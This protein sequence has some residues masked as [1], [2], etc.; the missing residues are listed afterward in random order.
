[1]NIKNDDENIINAF[2]MV[3]D[4]WQETTNLKN[5]LTKQLQAKLNT[6][7]NEYYQLFG[8]NQERII[9]SIKSPTANRIVVWF[10]M[11]LKQKGRPKAV[12]YVFFSICFAK[13]G[14]S[15]EHLAPTLHVGFWDVC[16]GYELGDAGFDFDEIDDHARLLENR[17]FS[18]GDTSTLNEWEFSYA[19][20][21]TAMTDQ[22]TLE[23]SVIRPL[24]DLMSGV[25][26]LKALPDDL[27]GLM[28]FS[29]VNVLC[30]Y[31]DEGSGIVRSRAQ[32]AEIED[33][34][35]VEAESPAP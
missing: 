11:S 15:P 17:L 8:K 32:H 24:I 27:P 10:P 9:K 7:D 12:A 5:V 14:I 3:D 13:P 4:C 20:H 33:T 26:V 18:W 6:L 31:S 1:M 22:A 28:K 16:E 21:L 23:R 19:L 30:A 2:R 29:D 25:P 35:E 34:P